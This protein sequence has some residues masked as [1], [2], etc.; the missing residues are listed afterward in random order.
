MA[1][2][3]S[4]GDSKTFILLG[5]SR[6]EERR[7]C[8]QE[9]FE[10]GMGGKAGS[11]DSG[12]RLSPEVPSHPWHQPLPWALGLVWDPPAFPSFGYGNT[13]VELGGGYEGCDLYVCMAWEL[14]FGPYG[15]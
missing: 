7:G 1:R 6:R 15:Y 8:R 2:L 3:G 14:T 9:R 12:L 10:E 4:D 5:G 11:L 13:E